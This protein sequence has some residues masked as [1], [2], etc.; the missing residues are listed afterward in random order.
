MNPR[1]RINFVLEGKIPDRI[2]VTLFILD[3]GHF[4]KQVYPNII[5]NDNI[6]NKFRVIDLQRELKADIHLR[7]W[8]GCM[9]VWM[10]GGGFNTE[11]ETDTWKIEKNIIKIPKNEKTITTVRT[12][13][14]SL[15]Q[16][17]TIAEIGPGTFHYACT[18]KPVKDIR[19][20][21]ILENFEPVIDKGHASYIKSVV[22]KVKDYLGEDGVI[23]MWISGGVFNHASHL[24]DLN[25]LYMLF[26]TDYAFYQRLMDFCFKRLKPYID[27]A[28][29]TQIDIINIGGNVAGGF[30]GRNIFE[31]YI[32]PFEKKIIDY[33]KNKG[34]KTLYHNCGQ[35]MA[36]LESYKDLGVDII[37]P[38]SPPPNLG[39][40]NLLEAKKSSEG[41]YII[42][43]NIDQIN[44]IQNGSKELIEKKVQEAA[45][46]GKPGGRFILQ[47][48]DF[49][50]YNT[51]VE[52]VRA[53]IKAGKK[54]GKY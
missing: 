25:D 38:F 7:L 28:A 17:F 6:A 32:L 51:P 3:E 36:L 10:F 34:L 39:D 8:K 46:I 9:P 48:S 43:G 20:L 24:I 26:L 53:Y 31:K 21:E 11:I 23:S 2:P 47:P 5:T 33:I 1:E 40:G 30:V 35:I 29:E 54:Y 12:P 41:K 19:D 15:S 13:A 49:L 44:V 27:A 42:C 52:N 14:G 37:E 4:L 50:E 16:E 18:K 22:S 45:S